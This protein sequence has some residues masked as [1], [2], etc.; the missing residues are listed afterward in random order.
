MA[1]VADCLDCGLAVRQ[2]EGGV[3]LSEGLEGER[4]AYSLCVSYCG[5]VALVVM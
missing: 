1:E 2:E 5:C 4:N 3:V